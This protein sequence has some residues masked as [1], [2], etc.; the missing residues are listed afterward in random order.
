MLETNGY[1]LDKI[2][3]ICLTKYAVRFLNEGFQSINNNLNN[4]FLGICEK[5]QNSQPIKV[6]YSI[7]PSIIASE[8]ATYIVTQMQTGV[9]PVLSKICLEGRTDVFKFL[10]EI[11]RCNFNWVIF[12]VL[13]GL[14]CFEACISINTIGIIEILLTHLWNPTISD[15]NFYKKIILSGFIEACSNRN[16]DM[17][18]YLHRKNPVELTSIIREA[19]DKL[20]M[21]HNLVN[22]LKIYTPDTVEC[23]LSMFPE[24]ISDDMN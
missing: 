15:A 10:T 16:I 12:R 22:L 18:K 9:N 6:F 8:S 21:S 3:E 19:Y 4:I 17:M 24:S 14:M 11:F 23:F 20:D 5:S 2:I 13:F 7:F 1:K